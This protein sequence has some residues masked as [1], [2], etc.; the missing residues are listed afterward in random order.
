MSFRALAPAAV[1]I[2]TAS[3]CFGCTS[4]NN[5]NKNK[6]VNGAV[7]T[8]TVAAG[9]PTR[10]ATGGGTPV[11]A[12]TLPPR[13]GTPAAGAGAAAVASAFPAG[14]YMAQ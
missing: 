8:T 14:S 12:A 10:T 13:A 1:L 3:I 6:P 2:L 7:S 9:T 5:K 4:S 11:T